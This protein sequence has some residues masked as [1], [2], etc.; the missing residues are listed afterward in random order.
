MISQRLSTA[1]HEFEAF[2]GRVFGVTTIDIQ[3]IVSRNDQSD[4]I[5]AKQACHFQHHVYLCLYMTF[6][7]CTTKHYLSNIKLASLKCILLIYLANLIH[8]SKLQGHSL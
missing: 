5:K 2:F 1:R 4:T 3:Y 7:N 8:L 6:K